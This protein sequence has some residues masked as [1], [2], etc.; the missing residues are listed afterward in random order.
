MIKLGIGLL[1]I[2]GAIM[3]SAFS[4]EMWWR[5]HSSNFCLFAEQAGTLLY[6]IV[7]GMGLFIPG[8]VICAYEITK[9]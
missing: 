4:L 9:P 8:V 2:G 7:P 3:F 5:F 6:M 1:G